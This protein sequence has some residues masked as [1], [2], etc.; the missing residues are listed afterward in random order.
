MGLVKTLT[1]PGRSSE[2]KREAP[3]G[4]VEAANSPKFRVIFKIFPGYYEQIISARSSQEAVWLVALQLKKILIDMS[5]AQLRGVI[6]VEDG[7]S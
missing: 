3:T 5:K 1:I 6:K 4:K 2:V 7:D